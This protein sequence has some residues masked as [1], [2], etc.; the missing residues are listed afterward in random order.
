VRKS[1]VPVSSKCLFNSA[2]P[3]ALAREARLHAIQVRGGI[4]YSRHKPFEHIYRH[5][6]RYGITE[7][8]EEIEMR[9]V[10]QL[11]FGFRSHR[12][13]LEVKG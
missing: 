12:H 9:R 4:G 3:A 7:G 10:A 11:L 5:H 8:S 1:H 2:A 6:P 13:G